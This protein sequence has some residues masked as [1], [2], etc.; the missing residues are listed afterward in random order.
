VFDKYGARLIGVNGDVVLTGSRVGGLFFF[1]LIVL[2]NVSSTKQSDV[3]HNVA[4]A[5]SFNLIAAS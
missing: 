2:G 4:P 3:N 5:R 1:L